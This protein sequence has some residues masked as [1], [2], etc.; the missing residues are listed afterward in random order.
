MGARDSVA[1]ILVLLVLQICPNVA[2][3]T[4]PPRLFMETVCHK[5]TETV[6][7]YPMS[8][9]C[10][11]MFDS[12][13]SG[14]HRG[15]GPSLDVIFPSA[16]EA[17]ASAPSPMRTLAQTPGDLA[18]VYAVTYQA[19]L[20]CVLVAANFAD[21][22]TAEDVYA[23]ATT[24]TAST[25]KPDTFTCKF[26]NPQSILPVPRGLVTE[27]ADKN[28]LFPG[29]FSAILP[30]L[31]CQFDIYNVVDRNY[32]VDPADPSQGFYGSSTS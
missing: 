30:R 11:A 3:T 28:Y 25:P 31:R 1:G 22:N 13:S 7:G 14:A 18:S 6:N 19:G 17:V 29:T 5:A 9:V 16:A 27:L 12:P 2:L 32:P 10:E 24:P 15:H 20:G 21:Q 4:G 26:T 8:E 23:I